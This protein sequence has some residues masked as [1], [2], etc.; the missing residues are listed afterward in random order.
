[1]TYENITKKLYYLDEEGV[2]SDED[3]EGWESEEELDENQKLFFEFIQKKQEEEKDFIIDYDQII[4]D[5][6]TQLP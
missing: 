4:S 6:E 3:E 5:L 2:Y 1:M